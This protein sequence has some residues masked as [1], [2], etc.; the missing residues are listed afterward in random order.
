MCVRVCVCVNPKEIYVRWFI[1]NI[2]GEKWGGKL[3]G[4]NATLA[5]CKAGHILFWLADKKRSPFTS[6]TR[7][8]HSQI[9]FAW[10]Q[11]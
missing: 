6:D 9:Y 4:K 1:L 10:A 11:V 3:N 7:P 5:N 2:W 8:K